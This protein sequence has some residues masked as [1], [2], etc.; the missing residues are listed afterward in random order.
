MLLKSKIEEEMPS[1]KVTITPS[2]KNQSTVLQGQTSS[3]ILKLSNY[4]YAP[5]AN[6]MLKTNAP[7]LNIN[8]ET[9]EEKDEYSPTSHCVG[10]SGTLMKVP[11]EGTNKAGIL[12]PGETVEVPVSIRTSGGGRQDFYILCRYELWNEDSQTKFASPR[13]RWAR[14]LLSIPVY[15]S[16]TMSA[17]LMPPYVNNGEHILSVELMNYRSDRDSG[18]DINFDNLCV[19][20]RHFEVKQLQGQFISDGVSNSLIH[21]DDEPSAL[22]VGW[23]ERVTLHYL[24][25]PIAGAVGPCNIS[26]LPL[27]NDGNASVVKNGDAKLTDF[28]CRERAHD[29]FSVSCCRCCICVLDL[30]PR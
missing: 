1:L 13:H 8:D 20:S 10:P 7:W 9:G 18:L 16:I 4:G 26:L 28:I 23:Q 25:A 14:K 17:S 29:V 12:Q 22:E 24:V 6:I 19:I 11:F 27:S 2:N 21:V 15:P 3:W 5:A 30:M